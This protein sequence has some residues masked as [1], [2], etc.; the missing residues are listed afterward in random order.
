MLDSYL[1]IYVLLHISRRAV[2][3]YL[4]SKVIPILAGLLAFV[5]TNCNL[6]IL[7]DKDPEGFR[8]W[9]WLA[10]FSDPDITQLKYRY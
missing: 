3:Q 1:P 5:D 10:M 9:L 6:D 4:E 8:H 2:V 7:S